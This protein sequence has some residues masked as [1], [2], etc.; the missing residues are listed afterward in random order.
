MDVLSCLQMC[1]GTW[2]EHPGVLK[3]ECMAEKPSDE[4]VGD[5]GGALKLLEKTKTTMALK[6]KDK[7]LRFK[8][9][10]FSLN[11]PKKKV[12]SKVAT[13]SITSSLD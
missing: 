3:I 4:A 5:E 13:T 10:D 12:T 9:N 6:T 11:P 7:E 8:H 1:V 2:E